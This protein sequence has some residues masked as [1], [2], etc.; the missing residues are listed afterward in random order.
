MPVPLSIQ[1]S[2]FYYGFRC[3]SYTHCQVL[4]NYYI[5]LFLSNGSDGSIVLLIKG[6][7]P[8]LIVSNWSHM[9]QTSGFIFFSMKNY[10]GFIASKYYRDCKSIK[11][12]F[13]GNDHFYFSTRPCC[14]SFVDPCRN[15]GICSSLPALVTATST[16]SCLPKNCT[17]PLQT[18]ASASRCL[19]FSS[20]FTFRG[21]FS[22]LNS[23][24]LVFL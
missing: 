16:R 21:G 15:R 8:H 9:L 12:S 5:R 2:V 23:R 6:P 10:L 20:S 3:L 17:E 24:R 22:A 4:M 19:H 1:V 18:T 11:S 7:S 14:L 13:M